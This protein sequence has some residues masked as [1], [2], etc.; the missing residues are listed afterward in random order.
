MLSRLENKEIVVSIG[1]PV[2]NGEKYI[3]NAIDSLLNQTF[4]NFELIISNNASTDSTENICKEYAKKDSRIKYFCQD[5]NLGA[6]A[7]F[8][9]TLDKANSKIFMW[10]AFDDLWSINYLEEAIKILSANEATDYVFSKFELNSINLKLSKYINSEL[11]RFIEL[12]N[13]KERLL[14]F[15]LLHH[16]S[17]KCNIVYSIFRIEFLKSVIKRQSIENDGALATL[18]VHSGIGKISNNT[19]FKKRYS[20]FWPGSFNFIKKCLRSN[21]DEN[22]NVAKEKSMIRLLELFPQYEEELRLI[23]V[24]YFPYS[25][26][27]N[28]QIC[29]VKQTLEI[30]K[31]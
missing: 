16:N 20:Y 2:Y 10:A 14:K 8:Q 28:Y 27:R 29:S 4:K 9:F 6:A 17:H 3:R 15:L 25:F 7:N 21:F 12:K 18:I 23:F 19:L 5:K 13:Q 11:F 30:Q 26:H 24:N 31:R 22:F 1:M